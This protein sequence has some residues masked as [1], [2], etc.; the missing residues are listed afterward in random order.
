GD[1]M[2]VG[3]GAGQGRRRLDVR[4]LHHAVAADVRVDDRGERPGG[5]AAD[6]VDGEHVARAEPALHGHLAV[7]GVEAERDLTGVVACVGLA[8]G[9]V[10]ERL[11]AEDDAG[12]APGQDFPDVLVIADAA[13]E[14]TRHA[15]G[16]HDL[17][18]AVAVDGPALASA[19]EIDEVEEGRALI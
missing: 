7:A 16:L 1:D 2:E 12:Y 14:L 6:E 4:A 18:D 15:G 3:H 8:P 11:G 10:F 19:V 5:A 9:G 17:P 13:A